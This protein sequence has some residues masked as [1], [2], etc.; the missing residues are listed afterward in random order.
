MTPTPEGIAARKKLLDEI[1]VE[2]ITKR[3]N[4]IRYNERVLLANE[5]PLTF[6]AHAGNGN[7]T[8]HITQNAERKNT[9]HK[10]YAKQNVQTPRT[11]CHVFGAYLLCGI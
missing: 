3:Y 7:S 4:L 6:S 11:G 10:T 9:N 1:I 8:G 5:K 2:Y